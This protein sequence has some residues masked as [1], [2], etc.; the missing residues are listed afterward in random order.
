MKQIVTFSGLRF[1]GGRIFTKGFMQ[2]EER[3]NI[4]KTQ[5]TK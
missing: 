5:T 3:K 4:K 2:D 1:L